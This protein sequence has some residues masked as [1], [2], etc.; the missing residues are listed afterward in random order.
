MYDKPTKGSVNQIFR[1]VFEKDCPSQ[2]PNVVLIEYFNG[3]FIYFASILTLM[4]TYSLRVQTGIFNLN[5]LLKN[6]SLDCMHDALD[7]T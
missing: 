1:I 6:K 5:I 7:F 3:I 4:D 2:F